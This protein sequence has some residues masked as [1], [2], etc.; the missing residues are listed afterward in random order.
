LDFVILYAT[1]SGNAEMV[2]FDVKDNLPGDA[3]AEI[4]DVGTFSPESMVAGPLY[5]IVS[6]THGDGE[7]PESAQAFVDQ[8]TAKQV[9]LDDVRFAMFGLGNSTYLDFNNGSKRLDAFLRDIGAERVGPYGLHDAVS[10]DDP[11]ADAI[12]WMREVLRG[13][14]AQDDRMAG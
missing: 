2:A 3:T 4:H 14:R 6:A 9:R 8:A 13:T 1:V 11:S 5:I 12:E 10:L 7:L